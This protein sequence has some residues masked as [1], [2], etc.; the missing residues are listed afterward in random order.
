MTPGLSGGM[1]LRIMS[2]L[3]AEPASAKTTILL[4]PG[5]KDAAQHYARAKKISLGQLI[6][7]TLANALEP[8]SA[9]IADEA[10]KQ[11]EGAP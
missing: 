4:T 10:R 1:I 5:L 2:L 6:R 11:A 3:L 9:I 7:V 8:N